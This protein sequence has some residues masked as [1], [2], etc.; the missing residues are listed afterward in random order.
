MG[1]ETEFADARACYDD[2]AGPFGDIVK[3]DL[4]NLICEHSIIY[5]RSIISGN[6]FTDEEKKYFVPVHQPLVRFHPKT[7]RKIYYVGSHCSHIVGWPIEKGRALVRELSGFC[8]RPEHMYSHKWRKGDLVIWDNRSVLHRGRTYDPNAR[9][10]M[11]R[12][13]VAGDGPLI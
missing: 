10:V 4:E 8:I 9:R 1:G 2:W 5:S 12:A 7:Y 3:E 6:I 13:T 11:H